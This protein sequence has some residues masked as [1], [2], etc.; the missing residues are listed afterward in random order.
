MIKQW[1]NPIKIKFVLKPSYKMKHN[2]FTKFINYV[3]DNVDEMGD[4]KMKKK[5]INFVIGQLNQK[6]PCKYY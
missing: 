2:T 6:C 1:Y 4:F 3:Y 5:I